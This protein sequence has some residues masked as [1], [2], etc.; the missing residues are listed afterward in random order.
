M[1]TLQAAPAQEQSGDGDV[2]GWFCPMHPD[3]TSSGP[4][5]CSKCGM[6][7]VPGNPFDMRDYVLDVT[8]E[9]RAVKAAVPFRMFLKVR[10]PSA[11]NEITAFQVVHEKQFHLFVISQDMEHFQHI[12]PELQP[13]GTWTITVTVPKPGYYRV[14]SDF[15]PTGGAPQFLGY[16]LVTADFD[17]DLRAQAARLTPDAALRKTVTG[18]T[19]DVELDPSRLIAGQYGHLKF[20]LHDAETGNPV[21]DLQPYLGAFGHALLLSEDMQ[22]YVHS[23]PTE[24]PE[25]DIS[26]GLGGPRVTF[27]GYMPHAGKFRAWVQFQRNDRVIT[28]PFTFS[29]VTLEEAMRPER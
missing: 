9:P 16:T 7:L 4:G 13:D 20:S 3:V 25:A 23:H 12:H 6:T 11:G 29:V 19:A 21:T 28:M 5:R 18:L 14:L 2:T 24:G 27:E 15:L 8:T 22:D 1:T 17:G 26:K 10:H